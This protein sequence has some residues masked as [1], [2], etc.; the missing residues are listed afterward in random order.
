MASITGFGREIGHDGRGP[1]GKRV[2]AKVDA[3]IRKQIDKH[4]KLTW[5]LAENA[6]NAIGGTLVSLSALSTTSIGQKIQ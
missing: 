5:A 1:N 4:E 3:E 6:A 2:R